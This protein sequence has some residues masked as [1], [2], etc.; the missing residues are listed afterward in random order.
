LHWIKFF[1][2]AVITTAEK[3]QETFKSILALKNEV[4]G[5]IVS[6]GR[7]AENARNLLLHLYQRPLINASSVSKMLN[8]TP[9][10]ANALIYDMVGLGILKEVT[11]F[12]RNRLFMF[13]KDMHLF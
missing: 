5:K 8:L 13:E 7:R 1:L 3:G 6:L 10:A 12:K 9:R 11:G 4:D 2:V